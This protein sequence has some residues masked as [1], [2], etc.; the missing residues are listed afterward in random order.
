MRPCRRMSRC[1]WLMCWRR[2][3]RWLRDA[4]QGPRG[5]GGRGAGDHRAALR[6]ERRTIGE[7]RTCARTDDLAEATHS[8]EGGGDDDML[9]AKGNLR[10]A[11]TLAREE[12]M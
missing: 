2:I 7:T 10:A 9:F 12:G 4:L 11:L 5:P 1:C 3:V 6:D 8:N